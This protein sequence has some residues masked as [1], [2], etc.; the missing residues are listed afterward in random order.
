[1]AAPRQRLAAAPISHVRTAAPRSDY[2]AEVVSVRSLKNHLAIEHDEDDSLLESIRDAAVWEIEALTRTTLEPGVAHEVTYD[3][4][5]RDYWLP[6]GPR[7]ADASRD[8]VVV[9]RRGGDDEL[10]DDEWSVRGRGRAASVVSVAASVDAPEEREPGEPL[11]T[12]RYSAGGLDA[13]TRSAVVAAAR[14]IA[15]GMYEAR[16]SEVIGSIVGRNPALTRL[17]APLMRHAPSAL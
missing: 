3:V 1:V 14:L 17:L 11:V 15:G 10:G 7:V 2:P 16:E 6:A 12:I 4:W 5:A 8:A 9:H 13:S